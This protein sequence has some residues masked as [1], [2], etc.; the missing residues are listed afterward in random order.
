MDSI[1]Y[2]PMRLLFFTNTPAHVHLYK[3]AVERLD[4][5]GHKVTILARDYGCTVDLLEYHDLPFT[6]YGSCPP[7]KSGLMTRLPGHYARIIRF[8]RQFDPDQIIG[9]GAYAA[10][11]SVVGRCRCMLVFDSE[12]T[13]LDHRLSRPFADVM[14][15]PASFRKHLGHKHYVFNGFKESAYLHPSVFEPDPMIRDELGLSS[16]EPFFIVRFNAFGSHHDVGHSGFPPDRREELVERL[17]GYATVFVSD[18]SGE[19]DHS[20]SEA[21]AFELHPARLHDA[22]AEA[23]LLVA[24]TQTIVTEA[25]LLGTPAVRSNSFVGADDMGNFID[26]EEA[27]LIVN[28]PTFDEALNAACRLAETDG[29]EAQWE[30]RRRQM[31]GGMANL[32]DLIVDLSTALDTVDQHPSISRMGETSL[33]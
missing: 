25:A 6:V 9:I 11:G 26:L 8:V 31:F 1:L 10:H 19:F 33:F 15:T 13:G 24:D 14:L 12:P 30:R 17:S 2:H 32:T 27:G 28:A 7:T 4:S 29:I 21:R 18:E 22:L 16:D 3:H 20:E 23:S 5:A